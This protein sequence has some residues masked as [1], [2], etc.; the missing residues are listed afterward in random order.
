MTVTWNKVI[1]DNRAEIFGRWKDAGLSLFSGASGPSS[2]VTETLLESMGA[3]LDCMAASGEETAG[4][5]D[6]ICRIL[7][8]QPFA[9]S[10]AMTVFFSL[11]NTVTETLREPSGS[12]GPGPAEIERFLSRTDEIILMAFDRYMKHREQLYKLKV[13][14]S[15]NSM[16]VALRRAGV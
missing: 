12:H 14:E 11:K 8:V 6:S 13:E 3:L 2:L 7:A 10:S 15:R 5:I 16:Y 4:A 1:Q 9:P